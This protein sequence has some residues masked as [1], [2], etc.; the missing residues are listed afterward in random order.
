M[1]IEVTIGYMDFLFTDLNKA[2]DFA[3]T[4]NETM[5]N[6]K[7]VSITITFCEEGEADE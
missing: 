1:N 4:A 2:V 6:D 3:K 5:K 7:D